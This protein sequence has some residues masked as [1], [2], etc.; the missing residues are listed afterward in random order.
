MDWQISPSSKQSLEAIFLE[1]EILASNV[2]DKE[3]VLKKFYLEFSK[4]WNITFF[5]AL[6]EK[7]L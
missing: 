6:S 7:Y 2:R 4:L 5:W 3:I 1:L